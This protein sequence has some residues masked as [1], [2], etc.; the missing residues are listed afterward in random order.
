MIESKVLFDLAC[1][2]V[3]S[4][5][6][7]FSEIRDNLVTLQCNKEEKVK[8]VKCISKFKNEKIRVRVNYSIEHKSNVLEKSKMK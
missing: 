8:R 1:T 6:D 3:R 2:K 5:D 7:K 4:N